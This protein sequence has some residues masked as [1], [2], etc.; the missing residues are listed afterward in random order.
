LSYS[1]KTKQTNNN[2]NNKKPKSEKNKALIL[3]PEA[4]SFIINKFNCFKLIKIKIHVE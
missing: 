4:N 3:G 1:R 2:N